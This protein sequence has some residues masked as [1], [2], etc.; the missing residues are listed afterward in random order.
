[1]SDFTNCVLH[2]S[3]HCNITLFAAAFIYVRLPPNL[4]TRSNLLGFFNFISDLLRFLFYMY[5]SKFQ[6]TSHRPISLVD[7]GW[8]SNHVKRLISSCVQNMCIFLNLDLGNCSPAAPSPF[9]CARVLRFST[10]LHFGG[11]GLDFTNASPCA[12]KWLT[13]KNCL[14]LWF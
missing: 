10:P 2:I 3:C 6:C 12:E 1:M 8:R 9:G 14:S 4:I 11:G 5:Y 13:F 7:W